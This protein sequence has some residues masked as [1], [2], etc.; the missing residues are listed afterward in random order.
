M[1][2]VPERK[3][4]RS[5][6]QAAAAPRAGAGPARRFAHRRLWGL[7]AAVPLAPSPWARDAG[8]GLV[9]LGPERRCL[10]RSRSCFTPLRPFCPL[11]VPPEKPVNISCWSKNMKDLTCKW[12]PGTEGE[13]FLH[14]NYTLKYKLRYSCLRVDSSYSRRDSGIS[15]FTR[16]GVPWL[17]PGGAGWD[18]VGGGV[19]VLPTPGTALGCRQ[20]AT[21]RTCRGGGEG[22]ACGRSITREIPS[23]GLF[24]A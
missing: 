19:P 24:G 9:L 12:A 3:Q 11:P 20:G 22:E 14:T 10:C 16:R 6:A 5:L 13:T 2:A 17:P 8:A 4:L 18:W 15:G 23:L 1:V 7:A 21:L